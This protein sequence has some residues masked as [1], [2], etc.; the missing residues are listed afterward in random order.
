MSLTK[1][2]NGDWIHPTEEEFL[3]DLV[4]HQTRLGLDDAG[5]AEAAAISSEAQL[6]AWRSRRS[7]PG[8][9]F[10]LNVLLQLEAQ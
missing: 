6:L 5:L 4:V 3:D 7:I 8:P 10:R 2:L 1:D 9:G